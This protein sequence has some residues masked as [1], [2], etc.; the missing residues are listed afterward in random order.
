MIWIH[1]ILMQLLAAVRDTRTGPNADLAI[2]EQEG[3]PLVIADL[4][5]RAVAGFDV[6]FPSD[7]QQMAAVLER[8]GVSVPVAGAPIGA[9]LETA[10]GRL[11]VVCASGVIESG[12]SALT[13]VLDDPARYTRA[14]LLPG[15]S[16]VGMD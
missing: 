15:A 16:Y 14:W 6:W 3:A 2:A 4:I 1:L 12:G 8:D 7:D 9:V 5:A 13:I 10:A 11:G